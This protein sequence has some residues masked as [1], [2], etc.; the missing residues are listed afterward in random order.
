M[1]WGSRYCG[2]HLQQNLLLAAVRRTALV[3]SSSAVT[4]SSQLCHR[5]LERISRD[6]WKL[7]GLCSR[8]GCGTRALRQWRC[9][10]G[11]CCCPVARQSRSRGAESS[12]NVLGVLRHVELRTLGSGAQSVL[13]RDPARLS[14]CAS[15]FCFNVS[16]TLHAAVKA[17]SCFRAAVLVFVILRFPRGRKNEP[18]SSRIRSPVGKWC[19]V[20]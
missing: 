7:S 14:L 1:N 11:C 12:G 17:E 3:L 15:A 5:L 20:E 10:A 6:S 18:F 13:R 2:V 16:V 9:L 19:F 8:R 4:E